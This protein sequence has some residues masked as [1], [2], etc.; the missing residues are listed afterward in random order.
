MPSYDEICELAYKKWEQAGRPCGDGKEFWLEAEGELSE[1]KS[2][3]TKSQP[4]TAPSLA[5]AAKKSTTK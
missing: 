5:K 4:T 2:R 1:K 3:S